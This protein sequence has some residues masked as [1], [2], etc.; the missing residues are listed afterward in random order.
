[1]NPVISEK[2]TAMAQRNIV[3][4]AVNEKANKH[5]IKETIEKLY[6]VKVGNIN[7]MIRKGKTKRVGKKMIKK[8]TT[9]IKLAL[10]TLKKGTID[11]FPKA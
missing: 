2:T 4:F 6:D 5:Q 7:M 9:D 11:L 8:N 10:I 3:T 1:M